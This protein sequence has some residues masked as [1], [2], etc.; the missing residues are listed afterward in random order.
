MKFTKIKGGITLYHHNAG[1]HIAD[2]IKKS[3]NYFDYKYLTMIQEVIKDKFGS[4]KLDI[5]EVGA[6]V[7]NHVSFYLNNLNVNS[8]VAVEPLKE[9]L[10]ILKMNTGGDNRV[11]IIPFGV[12]AKDGFLQFYINPQNY[13]AS[14]LKEGYKKQDS[15]LVKVGIKKWDIIDS[16]TYNFI[17]IDIEGGEEWILDNIS[18]TVI[19]CGAILAIEINPGT[20]ED[21]NDIFTFFQKLIDAGFY[22]KYLRGSDYLL[23]KGNKRPGDMKKIINNLN[24]AILRDNIW[25]IRNEYDN[26][27]NRS[28]LKAISKKYKDLIK[29]RKPKPSDRLIWSR[30]YRFFKR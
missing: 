17:K 2:I 26:E 8:I 3:K 19:K 16:S 1:D 18:D 23:C 20:Y 12:G 9:N 29:G 5:L 13:G 27:S 4:D 30:M 24:G 28:N 14:S 25:V 7:G 15:K 6:N 22:L 10:E 11:K 21:K